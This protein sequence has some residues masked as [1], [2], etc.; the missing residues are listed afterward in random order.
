LRYSFVLLGVNVVLP[1]TVIASGV[2]LGVRL[3]IGCGFQDPDQA[4]QRR[5][6][7]ETRGEREAPSIAWAARR[8]FLCVWGGFSGL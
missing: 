6:P 1:A 8:T 2:S 5:N 4:Q 7:R 3:P